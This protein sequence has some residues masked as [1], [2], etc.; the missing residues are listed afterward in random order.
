M[1]ADKIPAA[2]AAAIEAALRDPNLPFPS[3]YAIDPSAKPPYRKLTEDELA[4]LD[5]LHGPAATPAHEDA[6]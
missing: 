1:A 5:A 3:G 4:E 6:S 2:D